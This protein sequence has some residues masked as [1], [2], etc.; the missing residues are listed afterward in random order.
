MGIYVQIW[1]P[2]LSTCLANVNFTLSSFFPFFPPPY[3][4]YFPVLG[5]TQD[6][7]LPLNEN[8]DDDDDDGD[9]DNTTTNSNNNKDIL[10]VSVI[11]NTADTQNR[12]SLD[13]FHE[14]ASD[15]S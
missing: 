11:K 5:K 2:K 15:W 3:S 8:R 10:C 1:N 6:S 13:Q 12:G 7:K 14:F 9:T 4:S